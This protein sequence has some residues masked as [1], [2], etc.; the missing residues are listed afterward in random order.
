[1]TNIKADDFLAVTTTC[2]DQACADQIA[3]ALVEQQLAACIQQIPG[4]RS[5]YRWKGNIEVDS[6]VLLIA[7]VRANRFDDVA[8]SISALHPY[9]LPE[10]IALPLQAG[11]PPYLQWLATSTSAI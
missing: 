6:E 3:R 11:S 7:K 10:I 5:F 2:P 4:V 1:M 9:E 8:A